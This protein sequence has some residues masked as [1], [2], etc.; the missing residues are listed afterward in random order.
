MV[1]SGESFGGV[2]AQVDSSHTGIIDVK[3]IIKSKEG[4]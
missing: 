1:L 2:F 4:G 3:F